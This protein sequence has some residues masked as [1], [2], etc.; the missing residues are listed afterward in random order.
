VV[1]EAEFVQQRRVGQRHAEQT[2]DHP[3][4]R[5]RR[6]Q[7]RRPDGVPMEAMLHDHAAE[8]MADQRRRRGKARGHPLDI[9]DVV[10]QHGRLHVSAPSLKA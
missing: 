7:H 1:R 10:A 5:R 9:G 3:V 2:A 4:R 8:R 6:H